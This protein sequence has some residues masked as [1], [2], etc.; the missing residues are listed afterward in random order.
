MTP[1]FN[2]KWFVR[3]RARALAMVLLTRRDDLV[4]KETKEEEGDP[5]YTVYIN[6]E[7]SVGQRPFGVYLAATMTPVTLDVANKQLKPAMEQVQRRGPFQFPVCV[8]Y[9]TVKDDQGYYAWAYEPVVTKEGQPRL[10]SHSEASC[11]RLTDA[12]LEEIVS[13]VKR[14]YDVFYATITS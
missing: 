12:A 6:G 5:D 2:K 14:W 7:E 8:F 10:K 13:S 4:V 11:R 3:E 1:D 9:F